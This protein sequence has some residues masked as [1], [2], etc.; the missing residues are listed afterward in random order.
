M[1]TAERQREQP[2]G[3]AFK[4]TPLEEEKQMKEHEIEKNEAEEATEKYKQVDQRCIHLAGP[5]R[6]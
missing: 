2:G 4:L 6:Y 5:E 1:K 3:E